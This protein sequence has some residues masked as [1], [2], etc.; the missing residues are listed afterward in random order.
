MEL[1]YRLGQNP[2][3]YQGTELWDLTLVDPDN[4]NPVDY[5]R[6]AEVLDEITYKRKD[7]STLLR[8]LL[9]HKD[10][11]RI[12]LFVIHT[13]L[14]LRLRA[15]EIFDAG[16]YIPLTVHGQQRSHVI[17][18]ARRLENRCIAVLVPRNLVPLVREDQLP[19]S[20][21]VW[22]GTELEV[23]ANLRG[24]WRNVFT[25]ASEHLADRFGLERAFDR[26]PVAV[27]DA[28]TNNVVSPRL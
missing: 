10:D 11:G 9:H 23:P 3:F 7:V 5:A 13:L 16:E 6:R 12:K 17:A 4:R 2:D 20:A 21:S 1:F 25:G 28:Q 26:F 18:F 14:G 8:E 27:Y 19:T 15:K 24:S 22:R